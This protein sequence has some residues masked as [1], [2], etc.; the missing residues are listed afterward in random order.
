MNLD[1][2]AAYAHWLVGENP[3]MSTAVLELY[4]DDF[5]RRERWAEREAQRARRT[6]RWDTAW[7][8][9]EWAV[10]VLVIVLVHR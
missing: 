7:T 9:L 4:V 2:R 10:T 8:V 5:S 3:Q 6:K 1:D